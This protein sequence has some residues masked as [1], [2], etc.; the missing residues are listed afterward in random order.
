MSYDVARGATVLFGGGNAA[1]YFRDAYEWD[2]SFWTP[3]T[4]GDTR[5]KA[6]AEH[7][8]SYDAARAV[9]VPFGGWDESYLGDTWELT[10]STWTEF[11]VANSPPARTGHAMSYDSAREVAVLFGGYNGSY[12][13]D[14]REWDGSSWT[15]I[16]SGDVP[17]ARTGHAMS[18]DSTRGV[19]VLFGGY[20][21]ASFKVDTWEWDGSNWTSITPSGTSPPARGFHAMSYDPTRNATVLFG[22]V[23]GD[24]NN[25]NDTWEWDGQSWTKITSSAR[26]PSAREGHAMSYDSEREVIVLHGGF[27]GG[28]FGDLWERSDA[29]WINIPLPQ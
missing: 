15:Q 18:Y 10:G 19:T 8:M 21:S 25:F 5:P 28:H 13:S 2:G 6:R 1:S 14:T 11:N 3:I 27:D 17:P 22:G 4:P 7:A 26:S 16:S 12:L 23:D 9:T 29:E 20:D 24:Q